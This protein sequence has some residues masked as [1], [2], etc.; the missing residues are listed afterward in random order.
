MATG[1]TT[2]TGNDTEFSLSFNKEEVNRG[3]H[4]IAQTANKKSR[5]FIKKC[6]KK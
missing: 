3:I 4:G 6:L 2:I 1:Q 5:E